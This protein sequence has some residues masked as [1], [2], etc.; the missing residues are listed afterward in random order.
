MDVFGHGKKKVLWEVV[1]NHVVEDPADNEEIGLQGFYFNLFDK[2][3]EGFVREG[4]SEFPYLLMLIKQWP[5]NWKTQSTRTNHKVDEDNRKA[6]NKGNVRYRK[7]RWFS[8]NEFRKNIGC[9]I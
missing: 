2:D 4:S 9:L 1:D 3:E 6:L 7:F 8:S 5:G